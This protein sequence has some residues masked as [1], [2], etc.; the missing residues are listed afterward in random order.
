M[1]NAKI[2][3][4]VRSKSFP[5]GL[6]LRVVKRSQDNCIGCL[7]S[8]KGAIR[9]LT[10]PKRLLAKDVFLGFLMPMK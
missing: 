7:V 4:N 6:R 5:K 3:E 2:I 8:R 10:S 9:L 1:P